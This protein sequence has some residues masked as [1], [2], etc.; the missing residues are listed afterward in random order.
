[1]KTG[2]KL[3]HIIFLLFALV[4]FASRSDVAE[5][6]SVTVDASIDNTL[7]RV[8]VVE[9]GVTTSTQDLEYSG[10]RVPTSFDF[11]FDDTKT[12]DIYFWA[13]NSDPRP[14]KPSKNP[15][16]LLAQFSSLDSKYDGIL[17]SDAW[18]VSLDLL[19]WAPATEW[20]ANGDSSTIWWQNNHSKPIL[21]IDLN[22]SWIWYSDNFTATQPG[23]DDPV[24]FR[25]QLSQRVPEP[26]TVSLMM[27][28]LAGFFLRR[29]KQRA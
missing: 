28:G 22:A 18:E 7:H 8:W 16:G 29:R 25:F 15:G 12:V 23:V 11:T 1:M 24:Y 19:S 4:L 26:T 14:L 13:E 20:G 27:T 9:D 21:P 6:V 5:A 2:G 10:W 17:T 3:A